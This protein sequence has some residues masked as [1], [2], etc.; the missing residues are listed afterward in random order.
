MSLAEQKRLLGIGLS[1]RDS[2]YL[3]ERQKASKLKDA[4]E[5][6]KH[7]LK[8]RKKG[9]ISSKQLDAAE[10]AALDAGADFDE[11]DKL[12][13]EAVKEFDIGDKVR[14]KKDLCSSDN[15]CVAKGFVG[16]V[17]GINE[18]QVEI[19]T[20]P[21]TPERFDADCWELVETGDGYSFQELGPYTNHEEAHT[22][23]TK[24]QR[25]GAKSIVVD[26]GADGKWYIRFAAKKEIGKPA[27]VGGR[28]ASDDKYF[29]PKDL[30]RDER[31]A[32]ILH[33]IHLFGGGYMRPEQA[34]RT[35][36]IEKAELDHL[37]KTGHLE[38]DGGEYEL[39]D[40]GIAVVRRPLR[41]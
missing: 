22:R 26:K 29:I 16:R 27:K 15:R 30:P 9:K 31:F 24:L 33:K 41:K 39:T 37:V 19:L 11:I 38:K 2:V 14:A 12:R 34:K 6:F 7:A 36:G 3:I 8:L 32:R 5:A 17:V 13:S 1:V 21:L 25:D 28:S 10:N 20:T 23:A 35:W 40:K 18:R 4:V